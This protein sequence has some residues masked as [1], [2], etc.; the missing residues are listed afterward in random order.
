M[1]FTEYYT[2]VQE[3]AVLFSSILFVCEWPA[4]AFAW[5]SSLPAPRLHVPAVFDRARR[6][7]RTRRRTCWRAR[8][9]RPREPDCA[10]DAQ[11]LRRTRAQ[12]RAST[13][14]APLACGVAERRD[15]IAVRLDVS[16]GGRRRHVLPA[17]TLSLFSFSWHLRAVSN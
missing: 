1:L 3:C 2:A 16:A 12:R 15:A 17:L 7:E 10:G 13:R 5:I 9:A 6:P 4:R 11:R 14:I 8:V